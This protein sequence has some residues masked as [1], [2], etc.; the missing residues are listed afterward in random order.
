MEHF[1]GH[2]IFRSAV[3]GSWSQRLLSPS[4][5]LPETSVHDGV[6]DTIVAL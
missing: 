2:I 5:I 6:Y 3:P 1:A 4:D